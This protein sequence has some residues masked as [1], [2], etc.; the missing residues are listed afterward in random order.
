VLAIGGSDSGAGAGIQVDLKTLSA[1][2]IYAATA[3]TVV[4]AQNTRGVQASHVLPPEIVAAQVTAVTADLRPAAIK[5]GYL[6]T[7]EIVAVVDAV[8]ASIPILVVDPVLVST[9]GSRI[10]DETALGAY[11]RLFDRA[12]LLTPNSREA[13]LLTGIDVTDIPTL[14][15]AAAALASRHGVPVLVTGGHIGGPQSVDVLATGSGVTTLTGDRVATPNVHGTGCSLAG[16][17]TAR[18][19]HGSPLEQ[20]VREAKEWVAAAI[21]RA[22][23]W[24]LGTG[25][26][27][28]DHF[29]WGR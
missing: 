24:K 18:L 23:A 20:A 27:P 6:G 14:R 7:G 19:V 15:G 25:Q 17:I 11:R 9:E 12:T 22:A 4:T 3:I 13:A 28:I 2:G 5:T 29:G 16:S 8:A 1:H 10:V 21:Q 26:G